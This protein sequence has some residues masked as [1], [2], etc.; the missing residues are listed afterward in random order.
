MV[1]LIFGFIFL[2]LLIVGME[3]LRFQKYI[4]IGRRYK[5]NNKEYW[6][7]ELMNEIE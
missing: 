1:E 2:V 4:K 7:K 6:D 5:Y 3:F